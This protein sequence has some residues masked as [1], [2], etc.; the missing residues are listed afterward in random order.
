MESEL[1]AYREF[2]PMIRRFY[3]IGLSVLLTQCATVSIAR[4]DDESGETAAQEN[5][6]PTRA[7]RAHRY[8]EGKVSA[9][10]NWIDSFFDDPNRVAE[11]A[12]TRIRFRPEVFFQAKRDV[13]FRLKL[14]AKIRL[15]KLSR[16]ASLVI[17]G[18]DGTGDF[19]N[20]L[21]DSLEDPSIGLQFFGKQGEF[22]NT[23]LTAGV[24]LNDP[25]LFAGP[26]V[27]YLKPLGERS[28]FRIIQTVRWFT[29]NGWDSRTRLD[30]DHV[31]ENG[32]FLRQTVDGRWRA[33]RHEE[34]GFRTRVSTILTQRL[35]QRSGLQ[36]EWFTIFHTEPDSH[37]DSTT[38]AFRYRKQFKRDWLFYEVVPQIAFED[39]F[40][41]DPN[42]GIRFRIEII[43][44]EDKRKRKAGRDQDLWW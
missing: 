34:E 3:L 39:E 36:Y 16:K 10:A 41:W 35:D 8:V 28:Q 6:E 4:S 20:S 29:D 27:R 7:D 42:P 11:D 37:V 23:S 9:T 22:V 15:P 33:D 25:A 24:K 32:L 21:E 12:S 44:G 14:A 43:F 18:D 19:D 26:R 31:F 40:D 2:F 13:K 30:Y 5:A 38:L 17:G 1:I